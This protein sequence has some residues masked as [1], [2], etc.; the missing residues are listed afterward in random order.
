MDATTSEIAITRA[1]QTSVAHQVESLTKEVLAT[2]L[3]GEQQTASALEAKNAVEK[4]LQR[5]LGVTSEGVSQ[6]GATK[7]ETQR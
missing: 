5:V 6:L 3:A 4:E 1:A 7:K 2:R